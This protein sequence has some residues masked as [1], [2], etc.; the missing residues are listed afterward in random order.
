MAGI[1][2]VQAKNLEAT[3]LFIDFS[4][5]FDSIYRGKMEYILYTYGLLK[6]TVTSIIMLYKNMKA[7]VGSPDGDPDFFD[8][9]AGVLQRDSLAP[10][11]FII[12]LDYLL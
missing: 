9:F 4:K 6:E 7:M 10:Y 3:L 5:A 2:E 1:E 12:C 11:L 8:I